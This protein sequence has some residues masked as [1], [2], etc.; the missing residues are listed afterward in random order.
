MKKKGKKHLGLK[1]ERIRQLQCLSQEHLANVFGVRPISLISHLERTGNI[2]KNTLQE[3]ADALKTDP[4]TIENFGSESLSHIMKEK[5]IN[6]NA[7]HKLKETIYR[8]EEEINELKST[9]K[10][11]WQV[12]QELSKKA[13]S[14]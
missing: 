1:L 7:V 12:I 3:I 2:N 4:E 6:K 14:K 13:G 11:Q 10:E 8:Q 5:K 9:I